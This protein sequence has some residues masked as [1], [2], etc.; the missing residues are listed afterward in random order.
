MKALLPAWVGFITHSFPLQL[1]CCYFPPLLVRWLCES[2]PAPGR[3]DSRDGAFTWAPKVRE[4]VRVGEKPAP[5][6]PRKQG[7]TRL[8]VP[9]PALLPNVL[10]GI[11][12]VKGVNATLGRRGPATLPP[13]GP[14]TQFATEPLRGSPDS[15]SG[16]KAQGF[17]F[18]QKQGGRSVVPI[19]PLPFGNTEC[20]QDAS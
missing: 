12:P 20:K 8:A 11:L 15:L 6:E 19:Q 1:F 10:L 18:Q 7:Q 2:Q 4:K 16:L 14:R 9:C 13:Y 5:W 3:W 17:S